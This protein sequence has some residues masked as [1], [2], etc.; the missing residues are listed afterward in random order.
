MIKLG[1]ICPSEIAFRRFMPALLKHNDVDYVGIAIASKEEWFGSIDAAD[2]LFYPIR[3]SEIEKAENFKN[4]Y[5]GKI[6]E[7]YSM[8]LKSKEIDAVYI[9]LPPALHYKW[10]KLALRNNLHVY[11]EK[12]ST[13]CFKDTKELIKLAQSK[14][15]ALHENYMFIFHSQIE[16]LSCVINNGELGD[17]RLVRIDF[18]FPDRGKSDFRYN[19]ALGGGA[20]LDCGGYTFKYADYILGGDAKI[21]CADIG[22]KNG[23]SVEIYGCAT[24]RNHKG[25]VVQTSFGMDNDYRC[26]IDVWGSLGSL[27]SNRVLT[28]PANYEMTYEI[29]KNGVIQQFKLPADDAFFKSI[30]KFK[31]CIKND[32]T[33]KENYRQILKQELLVEQFAKLSGLRSKQ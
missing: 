15:I 9:P 2:S 20:L 11:L 3:E 8:M 19:R 4:T 18:G 29:S 22:Y 32:E 10:A 26:S 1:I 24:L 5:G 13:N 17:I 33:R 25:Q 28:P 27:R 14:K 12:P 6:F 31:E 7:S 16:K 30:D 23:Y 21:V